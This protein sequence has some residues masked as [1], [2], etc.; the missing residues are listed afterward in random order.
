MRGPTLTGEGP[1][2]GPTLPGEPRPPGQGLW[3]RLAQAQDVALAAEELAR[4]DAPHGQDRV[5]VGAPP[6][7]RMVRRARP[8]R[9]TAA[10]L[11][12]VAVAAAALFLLIP[13]RPTDRLRVQVGSAVETMAAVPSLVADAR[14]DLPLRFS[15]GSAVVFRAGSAGR[16]ESLTA[17]GSELVLEHGTLTAHVVHAST[18]AW[19]V[20]AGPYRV[21]VTGTRFAVSWRAGRLDL[22][23]FEG[24]VIVDGSVLGVGVPLT[25]G[26][27]LTVA[28]G[29]VRIEPFQ[30]EGP[31][32]RVAER[33]ARGDEG[34]P[35]GDGEVGRAGS[36][37]GVAGRATDEAPP[38]GSGSAQDRGPDEIATPS[39]RSTDR[40]GRAPR[41]VATAGEGAR[42]DERAP[43]GAAS[44]SAATAGGGSAAL[45]LAD[46]P[47]TSDALARLAGEADS[48]NDLMTDEPASAAR[49]AED[50]APSR[51]RATHSPRPGARAAH[52][53]NESW[54]ALAEDRHYPE[55]LAAARRL[56]WS[57]LC[58]HLDAHR[59]L[60]LADVARYSG[61]RLPAR[62][63][64]ESLARRFPH[65]RL[66][67]DAIFGLGRM[68][69]EAG[70][71]AEAAR[72][73]RRYGADWPNG[74]LA[75]EAA[76]R[77][78]E[79][80]IR[81]QDAEAARAAAHAYLAR[82][83]HGPQASLARGVLADS[84][85]DAP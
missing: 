47:R 81:L 13:R 38:A 51:R 65:D 30:P 8:V 44:P 31:V 10:A 5:P 11:A 56:G 7:R 33:A 25:A 3:W 1:G 41:G 75:D 59:L 60:T 53:T 23:L 83:P 32:P 61:A 66:A 26:R 67:A 39:A 79:S 78:V 74:P 54:L 77:L 2:Q 64:F 71:P 62:R 45:A 55:A 12:G 43:R 82:A 63:A 22:S 46:R 58:R 27:R 28:S 24:S 69:F 85:D 42:G 4:A 18:T 34:A 37:A 21:R 68:A 17:S 36:A 73:F 9:M 52:G 50:G 35:E 6:P 29:V 72:W 70:H 19:V 84:P 48:Q 80:A 76:G 14:A 20:H 49:A 57:N 16:L 40:G 15:D